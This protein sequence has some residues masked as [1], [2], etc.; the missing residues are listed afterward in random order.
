MTQDLSSADAELFLLSPDL[1]VLL[2]ADGRTVRLNGAWASALGRPLEDLLKLPF[3]SLV[4]VDDVA[5]TAGSIAQSRAQQG[6]QEFEARLRIREGG[7]RWIAWR[8]SV[9]PAGQ[10]VG[11]GRDVTDR[12]QMYQALERERSF[13]RRVLDASPSLISVKDAAGRFVLANRAVGEL[14]GSSPEALLAEQ[15][16]EAEENS[17][18]ASA[19]AQSSLRVLRSREPVEIE[20]P[21]TLATGEQRLFSTR[22]APLV[23]TDGELQVLAVSTDITDRKRSETELIRARE[24]ALQ[25]SRTKS[26]FLANMSHEIRT[27]LNGILGM[28]SL[29]LETELTQEQRDYLDAVQL[30][31]KNLL[32]IV[33]DILDLSKIEAQM[34]DVEAVPFELARTVEETVRALA[35]RTQEKGVELLFQVSKSLPWS[36]IGDPVR[37][38]QVLT[39][40]L[41]NAIKFTER[42]EI[43]VLVEPDPDSPPQ[44]SMVRVCVEDTGAGIRKDRQA[45]IFEAFTQEDGS[46]TRRFGGTG[47]GLTISRELVRR[48]GGRIWVE[49]EQGKGSTFRFTLRLEPADVDH[50]P[51][52]PDLKRLSALVV[53]DNQRSLTSICASLQSWN[54]VPQAAASA[55]EALV[56]LQGMMDKPPLPRILIID[57]QMPGSDGLSLCQVIET[58]PMLAGIPRLLLLAPGTRISREELDR[59]GIARA[60]SKPLSEALLLEGI[61]SA[62]TSWAARRATVSA[63]NLAASISPTGA[64]APGGLTSKLQPNALPAVEA[65]PRATS[66][67][68]PLALLAEDNDI[69]ALLARKML[70]RLGWKVERV[71]NGLRAVEKLRAG[72]YDVVLMDVQM[73]EMDGYEATRM[74]RDREQ[75]A[76]RARTPIIALTANA[77]KGDEVRCQE[78]G[79]D[80]YVAKP[81]SLESLRTALDA[82]LRPHRPQ[83]L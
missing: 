60:L 54:A 33:N 21:M 45:G 64:P 22:K 20:E 53:D 56:A 23:R 66:A 14:F 81:L 15:G 8:M 13:I 5:T 83:T 1:L 61:R 76:G 26:Q 40:L 82:A 73:P 48:M 11:V 43:V 35:P 57:A 28:T 70:E 4:H 10:I 52:R 55:G 71:S 68:A 77:M 30:S 7:E 51:P 44:S 42:G 12:R 39:N 18:A 50:A 9:S 49:S 41:G 67:A 6:S 37:F 59:A 58:E 24:Q 25:A 75:I 27:P 72:R 62:L 47:L 79:M 3:L 2:D 32:Q 36:V 63:M 16:G 65:P 19:Q 80:L 38:R 78:A 74:V 29:T 31:G 34:L 46:T 69:N 17:D